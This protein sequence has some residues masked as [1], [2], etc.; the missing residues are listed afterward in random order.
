M[1]P[2]LSFNPT[3]SGRHR[4]AACLHSSVNSAFGSTAQ[5]LGEGVNMALVWLPLSTSFA[6]LKLEQGSYGSSE[7]RLDFGVY[8]GDSKRLVDQTGSSLSEGSWSLRI[9]DLRSSACAEDGKAGAGSL[10]YRPPAPSAD[11]SQGTCVVELGL[12]PAGFASLLAICIAGK[13]PDHF[14]I[15]V[16]GLE[17]SIDAGLAWDRHI[18]PSLT[19]TSLSLSADLPSS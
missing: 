4:K 18:H 2:N 8:L 11:Q 7:A 3:R 12:S 9:R 10:R 13:L 15:E 19:V 1:R 16:D 5:A 14:Y 6:S 17:E